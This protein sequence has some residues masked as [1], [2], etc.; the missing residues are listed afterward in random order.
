MLVS[1]ANEVRHVA[2]PEIPG[3][4]AKVEHLWVDV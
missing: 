1:I 3:S 4:K 2:A